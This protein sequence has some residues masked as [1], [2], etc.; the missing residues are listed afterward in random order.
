MEL[1]RPQWAEVKDTPDVKAALE[2]P[3]KTVE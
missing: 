3:A 2:K 1:P